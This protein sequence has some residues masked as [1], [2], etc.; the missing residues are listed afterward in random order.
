M[1]LQL[2]ITTDNGVILNYHHIA[3]INIE[4]N[5]RIT[6]IVESYINEEARQYDKDY[7]A[8]KIKEDP[9]FPYTDMEYINIEWN[10]IGNLLNGD[11]VVNFYNWLKNQP[12]Y[13]GAIDV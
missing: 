10:D 8:G 4:I 9:T 13:I 1:A 12:N 6:L 5:Q 7:M 3:A 2:S 11:L